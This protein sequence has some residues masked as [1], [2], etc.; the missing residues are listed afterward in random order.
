MHKAQATFGP[1]IEQ[2]FTAN[3]W[4]TLNTPLELYQRKF[5]GRLASWLSGL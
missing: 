2:L 3:N 4:F 5:S 1:M